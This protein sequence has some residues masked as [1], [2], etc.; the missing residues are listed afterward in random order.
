MGGHHKKTKVESL[1]L[2]KEVCCSS[3]CDAIAKIT[4][5][6]RFQGKTTFRNYFIL[7]MYLDYDVLRTTCMSVLNVEKGAMALALRISTGSTNLAL[8]FFPR[9]SSRAC[10]LRR[11]RHFWKNSDQKLLIF[12]V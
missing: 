9:F 7:H 3:I 10:I 4:N 12:F 1:V 11:A 8:T 5:F 2:R 6:S